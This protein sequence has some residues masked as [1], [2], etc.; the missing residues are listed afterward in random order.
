MSQNSKWA[1]WQNL[2]HKPVEVVKEEPVKA[3][4]KVTKIEEALQP[5]E[6]VQPL[7]EITPEP[8]EVLEFREVELPEPVVPKPKIKK[9]KTEE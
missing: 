1:A 3:S 7:E 5:V 4:P 8:T 2:L 6:P 9:T